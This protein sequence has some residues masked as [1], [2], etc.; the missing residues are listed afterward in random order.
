MLRFLTFLGLK[1]RSTIL[2]IRHD[3][4]EGFEK[5]LGQKKVV[6]S[7]EIGW[8]KIVLSPTR[9]RKSN[10]CENIYFLFQKNTHKLKYFHWRIYSYEFTFLPLQAKKDRVLCFSIK[11]SAVRVVF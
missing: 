1:I 3:Q 4:R 9:P 11:K 5:E 7:P 10:V 6:L 2:K 8:M